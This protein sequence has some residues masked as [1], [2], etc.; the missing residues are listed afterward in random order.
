MNYGLYL[1]ASGM[2]SNLYRQDVFANNL[3]NVETSGFKP[4]V[5][6]VRHRRPESIEDHVAMRAAKPMLDK[7]GGGVLAG[8]QRINFGPAKL[9]K[10]GN[11][12]DV[13]LTSEN[14]F[15]A[16]QAA[17]GENNQTE[18]ALTRDGQFTRNAN[19]ELVTQAGHVVLNP[20][21]QPIVV[22]GDAP[23]RINSGGAIMQNGQTIDQLQVAEVE[24]TD[25]LKKRGANLFAMGE[26]DPRQPAQN[27]GVKSG[28]V[29]ASAVDPIHTLTK[30]ISATKSA[31]GNA[32]MIK[33]HD[34]L[35]EQA[36]RTLGRV[37]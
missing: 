32:K 15:F 22:P 37:G 20:N 29:E 16:V 10:T 5:P 26:N 1:S 25:A 2:M 11:P 12:L 34:R 7:L 19:G 27:P 8:P 9:N 35:M 4:D 24:N 33:Y 17:A 36:V 23:V 14:T 3:A 28:F 31:T 21:D 13:A 30:L 18:I 6:S